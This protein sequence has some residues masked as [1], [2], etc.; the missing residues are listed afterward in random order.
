MEVKRHH[1]NECTNQS[2]AGHI[3]I[4]VLACKMEGKKHRSNKRTIKVMLAI[5]IVVFS[6]L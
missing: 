3:Q 4:V 6:F 2:D 5:F 1:S